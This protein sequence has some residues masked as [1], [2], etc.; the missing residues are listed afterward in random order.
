MPDDD[1]R[2][3][4]PGRSHVAGGDPATSGDGLLRKELARLLDAGGEPDALDALDALWIARLS[5]LG[6]VDWSLIGSGNDPTA[7]PLPAEPPPDPMPDP[8]PGPDLGAETPSARIHLPGGSGATRTSS[9]GAHA[10]RVAQPPALIDALSLARALRPLRRAVASAGARTLDVQATAAASGDTGLLL[11]VLRPSAE[12]CFSIDLLIDV[13]TT[14]TVWHRLAS[15]LRTLLE[16]HGAFADIRCWALHTDEPEPRLAPFRRGA[17][18]P[19]TTR[20]WR[21]ALR[22]PTGRRVVLVL[23][24]GVGPTWYGNE[25]PATLAD[26]S[27]ERPVAALQVLPSRLW[28]RTALRTSPVRARGGEAPRATLQVRTSGPLPGIARGRAGAVDRARIRWL[29]VLEVAGPWLDPWARLVSGRTTDWTPL[30]AAPLTVVDRPGLAAPADEPRT[31]AD[32]IERFEA[33]YS[34][35]AF[36]LLRLLAAAPLSLPVMR[37]VQRTMLPNTATPMQLSE[38]FLSG[39][40]VRRTPA[41][42]S[43]DPDA[44]LYDFRDGVREALLARLTRTESLSVLQQ[45]INGVSERVAETLGGG[46][47]DFAALVAT[48]MDG[49]LDGLQLPEDS[50]AFAEVALAVIRG[51]GG[52]YGDLVARLTGVEGTATTASAAGP[53]Q[54]EAEPRPGERRAGLFWWLRGRARSGTPRDTSAVFEAEAEAEARGAVELFPTRARVLSRVPELPE[55]YVGRGVTSHIMEVLLRAGAGATESRPIRGTAT[56]V[57]DGAPGVGKTALAIECARGAAVEFTMVRWIRAHTREVLVNDLLALAADLGLTGN[58]DTNFPNLLMARLRAHLREH[59]G[60]LLIYDGATPEALAVVSRLREPVP[61]WLPPEGYGSVLVT[62]DAGASWP[63]PHE[64]VTLD[65]FSRASALAYLE[66]ALAPQRGELWDHSGELAD[67]V[68]VTGT[69]RP[70]DLEAVALSI[71]AGRMPVGAFVQRALEG[72]AGIA[73]FLHSLVWISQGDAFLGTGVVVGPRTVLTA[74]D[75]DV[76]RGV[77]YLHQHSGPAVRVNNPVRRLDDPRL[78]LLVMTEDVFSPAPLALTAKRP[79]TVAAWYP[80][81]QQGRGFRLSPVRSAAHVLPQGTALIDAAGRLRSVLVA[82]AADTTTAIDVTPELLATLRSRPPAS[83]RARDR[84]PE[85]I[86]TVPPTQVPYFYLSYARRRIPGE[87]PSPEHRF[88][89]DLTRTIWEV[90]DFAGP[91][92]GFFDDRLPTGARWEEEMKLALASA[93]VFIPLYSPQYFKSAWCGMEWDA[94][95]R[96]RRLARRTA[97]QGGTAIVPIQWTGIGTGKLVLPPVVREV[98][99]PAS[100]FHSRYLQAGLV[101]LVGSGSDEYRRVVLAIAKT[102]VDVAETTRLT[103]CDISL[104]DDLHNVFDDPAN[105]ER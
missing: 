2:Q 40:L 63:G 69:R 31:P 33:G 54:R 17:Q 59:P 75:V 50:R 9:G 58:P 1:N 94:F 90:T 47:T 10:I 98:Q 68:E 93:R 42:P 27:R 105:T 57:I 78:T 83:I 5:G 87:L 64:T 18:T 70:L 81:Q 39:L 86:S 28:H 101:D 26:W 48:G 44:V 24:D 51:A 56:C 96:R 55:N 103:P 45:V 102:V 37:L 99:R 72:R 43:E 3:E 66:S 38:I 12:R 95:S 65:D 16:R 30:R 22:D 61:Q 74:A 73:R 79:V 21:E 100:E 53:E 20:R 25:L 62:L 60:W 29:P 11:P 23:T 6:P 104:F 84:R 88:F 76:S 36:R 52:D 7:P 4:E 77:L 89:V 8:G 46:V 34:S 19:W 91:D 49:G 92:L 80:P 15:E 82:S 14:M 32:W 85:S 35:D 71:K 97:D 67:L 41:E 13:G